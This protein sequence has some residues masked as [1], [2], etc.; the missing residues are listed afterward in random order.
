MR[1][2]LTFI[3]CALLISG[4]SAVW[5]AEQKT[6]QPHDFARGVTLSFT[7]GEPFYQLK[8]PQDVY[9]N[10]VWPDLRD[11]RI[12]NGSG[13][14]VPYALVRSRVGESILHIVPL[15]LFS[16]SGGVET[17][18]R[19][20]GQPPQRVLHSIPGGFELRTPVEEEE[21]PTQADY[22]LQVPEQ[23]AS[24]RLAHLKLAWP[25][26]KQNWRVRASIRGSNDLKSW[27]ML[28]ESAPLMDLASGVERLQVSDI[29][30]NDT[31][32]SRQHWRYFWLT[33]RGEDGT[34]TT[35]ARFIPT[36]SSVQGV[37]QDDIAAPKTVSIAMKVGSDSDHE[38]KYAFAHPQMLSALQ[39]T[40]PQ[41]NM[42]FPV[43]IDYRSSKQDNWQPLGKQVLYRFD[44]PSE[45]AIPNTILLRNG[46]VQE[47]RLHT[48]G[49]TRWD[50][51]LPQVVGE[52]EEI[53]LI[54]NARGDGPFVLAWGAYAARDRSMA[55]TSLL[56]LL[57]SH[58]PATTGGFHRLLEQLPVAHVDS[59][60][61]LGGEEKLAV[62]VP[63]GKG[64]VWK[65]MLLWGVLIA[66]TLGLLWMVIRLWHEPPQP[67]PAK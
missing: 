25:P 13:Q 27:N 46:T 61:T 8:L 54:F 4:V 2:F 29:H 14:L 58:S 65:K 55:L 43:T 15:S 51:Q 26:S 31:S 22:L 57:K 24:V 1:Y 56:P 30:M 41:D 20:N 47:L 40:L 37:Y 39:I 23:V 67:P 50:G 53:T 33:L 44:G 66:G 32:S 42:V 16:L 63:I 62:L 60:I 11:I 64:D 49:M 9:G 34:E 18:Q 48:S 28:V 59:V 19:D 3:F 35:Q 38:I 5:A 10:T 21:V 6:L 52:R 45:T 36:I 17:K 7:A 12:F